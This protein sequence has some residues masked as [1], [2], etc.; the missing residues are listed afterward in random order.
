MEKSQE[1]HHRCPIP[2]Q[3]G[4]FME[5][6][7]LKARWITQ[8]PA[9]LD[10][11]VDMFCQCKTG[12]QSRCCQCNN[13]DLKCTDMCRSSCCSNENK[14]DG[15][16]SSDAEDSNDSSTYTCGQSVTSSSGA[17]TSPNYPADYRNNENCETEIV[18]PGAIS[19]T[20]T[21]DDIF[22]ELCCDYLRVYAQNGNLLRQF[23][24]RQTLV[25]N[26]DFVKVTFATD[27]SNVLRGFS[28]RWQASTYTCGES[29]MGLSGNLTSP[30]YPAYYRNN[31]NCE[32]EI[33][34]SGVVSITLTV[35]DISLESCCDFLR[36]YAQNGT[37]LRQ[38]TTEE[39]LVIKRDFVK[40]TFSTD[41]SS[42]RRG[43]SMHWQGNYKP[44]IH[45]AYDCDEN[46]ICTD[47]Y[48]SSKC[49]CNNHGYEMDGR[50][51]TCM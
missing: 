36:V 6:G 41:G 33:V 28:M 46:T 14:E 51:C 34:I 30:N 50:S 22:L 24:T 44:C 49:I 31:E 13:T 16:E 7:E 25:I 21:V 29:V 10:V 48:D 27:G 43:F 1:N 11:L 4:W 5:D 8:Q 23:T 26:G 47:P 2:Q 45:T 15:D 18:L 40:I 9:L 39:T 37:L 32:T 38:F 35:D 3:H 20:L 12:C 19:I 17:L 42:V